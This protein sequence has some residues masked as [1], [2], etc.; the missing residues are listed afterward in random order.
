[1]LGLSG[2]LIVGSDIPTPENCIPL[3]PG[4]APQVSSRV[5]TRSASPRFPCTVKSIVLSGM[6]VARPPL[7]RC[8]VNGATR[9]LIIALACPLISRVRICI[10]PPPD[11]FPQAT[12]SPGAFIMMAGPPVWVAMPIVCPV[13]LGTAG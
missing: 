13:G 4:K 3:F 7:P 11:A 8:N 9:P 2:Q 10:P 12:P 6:D 5:M 1:M